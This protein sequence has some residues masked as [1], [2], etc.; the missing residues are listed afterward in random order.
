MTPLTWHPN[1]LSKWIWNSHIELFLLTEKEIYYGYGF[2]WIFFL[3][4]DPWK[5]KKIIDRQRYLWHIIKLMSSF[6]IMHTMNPFKIVSIW[7]HIIIYMEQCLLRVFHEYY[8]QMTKNKWKAPLVKIWKMCRTSLYQ[9]LQTGSQKD[10]PSFQM[11]SV[12]VLFCSCSA[13]M[14]FSLTQSICVVSLNLNSFKG[15][16]RTISDIP[17]YLQQ[18]SLHSSI[19]PT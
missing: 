18:M 15:R 12:S 9:G 8:P 19:L 11:C 10:K 5:K 13:S 3:I 4:T 2:K 6:N 16:Q 1:N 14:L 17:H 7:L